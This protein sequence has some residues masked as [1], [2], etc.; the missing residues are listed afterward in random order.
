M[1]NILEATGFR[2]ATAIDG[3]DGFQRLKTGA[4]DAVVSDVGNAKNEQV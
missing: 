1:K 2:V 4:F 3:E